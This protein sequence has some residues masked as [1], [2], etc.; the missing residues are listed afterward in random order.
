M[1]IQAVHPRV[2]ATRRRRLDRL[3]RVPQTTK[4][5][6][7]MRSERHGPLHGR[8]GQTRQILTADQK[9]QLKT[10]QA[11]MKQHAGQRRGR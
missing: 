2:T 6:A 10:M 11:Q 5:R 8:P 3:G 9:T 1:Q 4:A 7:A